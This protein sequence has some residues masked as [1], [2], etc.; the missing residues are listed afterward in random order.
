MLVRHQIQAILIL[1]GLL[2]A[3]ITVA[4][5]WALTTEPGAASGQNTRV[6]LITNHT[7]HTL[8]IFRDQDNAIK[9]VFT[10][11]KG[12]DVL[13]AG[14]CPTLQVDRNR[15]I[16]LS[17]QNQLC[18]TQPKRAVL[19][20]GEISQNTIHSTPLQQIMSGISIVVRFH[21]FTGGYKETSFTLAGSGQA[22]HTV[23]N[24]SVTVTSN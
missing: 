7:G 12:F 19:D 1:A 23:L 2:G 5:Q 6:A 9:G 14:S 17:A 3:P 20:F 4:E 10:L 8:R 15:P 16:S 24:N 18:E 21:L 11:K 22:I 13:A